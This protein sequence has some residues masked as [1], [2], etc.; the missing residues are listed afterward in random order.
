[1]I[2]PEAMCDEREHGNLYL[3]GFLALSLHPLWHNCLLKMFLF[4][5]F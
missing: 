3:V 1:M 5:T 2:I 4:L